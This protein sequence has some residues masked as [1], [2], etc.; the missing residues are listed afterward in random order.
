MLDSVYIHTK[1]RDHLDERIW[2]LLVR[3]VEEAIDNWRKPDRGIWEVR[4]EPRH[5]TSS[6]VMCWVAADRGARLADIRGDTGLETRWRAAADEM[7]ADILANGL[8]ERGVF[9][10][11]YDT[12]ALDASLLLLPLFRFLPADD[13]RVRRTVLAIADELSVD[14][15]VRR[16]DVEATDDGLSGEEGAFLICAFWLVSALVE[17]G[18]IDRARRQCERLLSKASALGLYGEELD[19]ETGRH[20]GNFPQAF[21]HLALINAVMHVIGAERQMAAAVT[22]RR[23]EPSLG[24]LGR[25]ASPEPGPAEKPESATAPQAG[26][27]DDADGRGSERGPGRG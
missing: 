24:G 17:I 25:A 27:G 2:P 15:L 19:P 10:Q 18:E 16:Y 1:S 7:K 9:T 23:G 12:D 6:K 26:P 20:L 21:T 14:G 11:H 5:F 8:D 4:G 13:E 3:Q 22:E